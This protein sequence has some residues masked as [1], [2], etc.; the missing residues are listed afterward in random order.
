MEVIATTA[1][2]LCT[3]TVGPLIEDGEM[4]NPHR[5]LCCHL[6]QCGRS[7]GDSMLNKIVAHLN[8]LLPFCWS[9]KVSKNFFDNVFAFG[10]L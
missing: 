7:F 1:N 3:D 5:E 10:G 8:N 9:D 2:N 6:L 4:N